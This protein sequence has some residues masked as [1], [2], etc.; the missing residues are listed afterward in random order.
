MRSAGPKNWSG[1]TLNASHMNMAR[2]SYMDPSEML[3][4]A[5]YYRAHKIII[6]MAERLDTILY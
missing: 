6:N 4:S 5:Q 1:A 3:A 2:S